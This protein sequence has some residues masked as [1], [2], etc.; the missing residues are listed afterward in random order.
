MTPGHTLFPILLLILTAWQQPASA[1]QS[2]DSAAV[3]AA[4]EIPDFQTQIL[5]LLTRSGCN[6][7]ACH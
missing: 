6:A 7:G 1:A 2:V 3:D 5:P 4:A